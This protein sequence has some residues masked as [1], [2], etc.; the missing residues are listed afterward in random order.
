MIRFFSRSLRQEGVRDRL[1]GIHIHPGST[2][3][4][5]GLNGEERVMKRVKERRKRRSGGREREKGIGD[6]DVEYKKSE[7]EG[8][9]Q[10]ET[11]EDSREGGERGVKTDCH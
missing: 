1:V 4:V 6:C 8:K 11:E 9:Q 10:S 2:N 3:G 5:T 7:C